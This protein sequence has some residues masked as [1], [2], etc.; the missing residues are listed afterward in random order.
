MTLDIA[1][2]SHPDV[3]TFDQTVAGV[4]VRLID[5][6]GGMMPVDFDA[7]FA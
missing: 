5:P 3:S 2:L 7:A 4:K 1:N 6:L